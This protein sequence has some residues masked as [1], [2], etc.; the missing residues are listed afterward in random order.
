MAQADRE[1]EAVIGELAMPI[2][3]PRMREFDDVWKIANRICNRYGLAC[4]RVS[5][6]PSG[7]HR[8]DFSACSSGAQ[9]MQVSGVW[10]CQNCAK[11]VDNDP[12]RFTVE[13]LRG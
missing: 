7:A 12:A 10:L 4:L 6:S 11:L 1:L 2:V 5:G 8:Y 13:L 3:V 9:R